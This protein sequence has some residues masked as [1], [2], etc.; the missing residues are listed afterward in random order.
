MADRKKYFI[1]GIFVAAAFVLLVLTM[2]FLGLSEK[3]A[4][5][6]YFVTTFSESVQGLT[7][8]SAVKYKGVPIGQVDRISILPQEKIIRVDMSIDPNVFAG[9]PAK[10]DI[11]RFE[12]VKKF[13]LQAREN[14][15]CCRLDLAGVTGMRYI[16]MDYIPKDKQ[17][18]IPLPEINDPDVIYFASVPGVFANII[19]SVAVS[20]NNIAR[21]DIKKI[22][23]DLGRNLNTLGVILSDPAIKNTLDRLELIAGNVESLSRSVAENLT[24]DELKN[25]ISG[26]N[27]NLESINLLTRNF[28]EKLGELDVRELNLQVAGTLESCKNLLESL[29]DGKTDAVNTMQQLNSVLSNLNEFI[30]ELKSDPGALVRGRS[31][32]PVNLTE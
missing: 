30:T 31:A 9:L 24:G 8:G 3:F 18:K 21:V 1:T 26:V 23:D 10:G 29:Q 22:S 15:L 16:E 28:N 14:N 19:D 12:Q 25:L 32:A 13:C 7:K 27:R 6:I 11:S 5:R 17:R 2:F 4:E 20:L